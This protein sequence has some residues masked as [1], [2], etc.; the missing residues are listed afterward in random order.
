MSGHCG[1][2]EIRLQ[3]K[4]CAALHVLD[5]QR[6]TLATH[7]AVVFHSTKKRTIRNGGGGALGVLLSLLREC[8]PAPA[9]PT[10][11]A[12]VYA[13]ARGVVCLA[14]VGVEVCDT[15]AGNME[16]PAD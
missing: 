12:G 16:P 9:S 5:R 7:S 3:L 6:Q 1:A 13:V 2:S 8:E 11:A 14:P 4:V 15:P 10:T